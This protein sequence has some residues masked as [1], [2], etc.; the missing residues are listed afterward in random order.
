MNEKLQAYRQLPMK[1]EMSVSSN[2]VAKPE[3][4]A[5]EKGKEIDLAQ[6]LLKMDRD[7]GSIVMDAL[8]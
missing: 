5:T 3:K 8:V 6:K 7:S 4:A 2:L 1:S